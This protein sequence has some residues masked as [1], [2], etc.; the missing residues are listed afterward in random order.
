MTLR[1]LRLQL[2]ALSIWLQK[3]PVVNGPRAFHWYPG[4]GVTMPLQCQW[5]P[6][7]SGAGLP[8]GRQ[9]T[10]EGRQASDTAASLLS[11]TALAEAQDPDHGQ[12]HHGPQEMT[13]KRRVL[14]G[15]SVP[16]H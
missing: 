3:A 9:K 1:S 11:A 6:G 12:M 13:G 2:V 14:P 8:P 7:G 10:Q 5:R 15:G 16:V 4:P